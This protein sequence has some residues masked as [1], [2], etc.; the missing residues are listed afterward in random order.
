L[1]FEGIKFNNTSAA[2]AKQNPSEALLIV[3]PEDINIVAPTKGFIKGKIAEV[4]YKG[5]MYEVRC[6]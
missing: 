6:E 1:I 5:L 2:L 3:R 4:I